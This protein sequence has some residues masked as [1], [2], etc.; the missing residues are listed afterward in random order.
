M[1]RMCQNCEYWKP[2]HAP[3]VKHGFPYVM[4]CVKNADGKDGDCK[5][6]FWKLKKEKDK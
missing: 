6:Y 1:A 2:I 3:F 5:G 4:T